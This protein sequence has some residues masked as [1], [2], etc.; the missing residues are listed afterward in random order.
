MMN[1]KV[2]SVQCKLLILVKIAQERISTCHC[3][4]EDVGAEHQAAGD[5]GGDEGVEVRHP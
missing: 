2:C 5:D 3:S 4:S 1:N